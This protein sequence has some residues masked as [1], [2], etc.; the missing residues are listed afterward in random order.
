LPSGEFKLGSGDVPL[1]ESSW[2]W[3]ESEE[4][5]G[6]SE[7]LLSCVGAEDLSPE[8]EVLAEEVLRGVPSD[9]ALFEE[10]YPAP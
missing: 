6:E 8:F 4:D 5:E 3:C 10:A 9:L 7:L 2:L 1:D